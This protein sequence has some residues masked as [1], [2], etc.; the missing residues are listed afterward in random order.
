MASHRFA[1]LR[2]AEQFNESPDLMYYP[3]EG[4]ALCDQKFPFKRDQRARKDG[5]PVRRM[6][7]SDTYRQRTKREIKDITPWNEC[8]EEHQKTR[9][10]VQEDLDRRAAAAERVVLDRQIACEITA[11]IDIGNVLL[12]DDGVTEETERNIC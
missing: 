8:W 12:M 2:I 4:F 6:F 7:C 10:S 1:L 5:R 9:A 11:G 3:C